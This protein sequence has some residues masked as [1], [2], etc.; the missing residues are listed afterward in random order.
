[1]D[2][3]VRVTA[4][5]EREG[6]S[7]DSLFTALAGGKQ[8]VTWPDFRALFAQLE[9]GLLEEHLAQLWKTFDKNGD[10]GVSREEFLTAFRNV[11]ASAAIPI[12]AKGPVQPSTAKALALAEEVCSRVAALLRR[13]GRTEDQL[14]DA[15]AAGKGIVVWA[16]FRALFH[17]LEAALTEP[18]LEELWRVFDKDGDGGVSRDEFKKSLGAVSST[19]QALVKEISIKVLAA[20]SRGGRSVDQLFDALSS[21]RSQVT[22]SDFSALFAQ[23]EPTLSTQQLEILWRT[24]D[25]DG[26]GGVSREEFQKSL[27][28]WP[29]QVPAAPS[30]AASDACV[31]VAA[32]LR[33]EGKTVEMLFDALSAGKA[34]VLWQDF[35][36]LFAQLEP[37][38]SAQELEGLWRG[39]DKDGDGGVT[40]DEFT[41]ALAPATELAANPPSLPP[42]AGPPEVGNSLA[43]ALW[44]AIAEVATLRAGPGLPRGSDALQTAVVQQLSAFDASRQGSLDRASFGQALRSYS[45]GLPDAAIEALWQ[46]VAVDGKATVLDLA[47]RLL[48]TH[49][50]AQPKPAEGSTAPAP[51]PGGPFWSALRRLRPALHERGLR[52]RQAFERMLP[53]G[54]A[55]LSQQ[56]LAAGAASLVGSPLPEAHLLALFGSMTKNV[57]LGATLEE[58]VAAFA[59]SSGEG[60]DAF[61]KELFGRAGRSLLLRAR[62]SLSSAFATLDI[63]GEGEI[64]KDGFRAALVQFGDLN[65][66][67]E[68]VDRLWELARTIGGYKGDAIDFASFKIL[69]ASAPA[70]VKSDV[71]PQAA[72]SVLLDP[73]PSLEESCTHLDRLQRLEA[74]RD[75]V[76]R[77]GQDGVVP[78]AAL[79]SAIREAAPELS[80][81]EVAQ[82]CR[83]AP[84]RGGPLGREDAYSYSQLFERFEDGHKDWHPL[85]AR[86]RQAAADICRYLDQRVQAWGFA[87][88]ALALGEPVQ[89]MPAPVLLSHLQRFLPPREEDRRVAELSLLRLGRP[90]SGGAIDV[91]ELCQR[92]DV[93]ARGGAAA[94]MASSA[95]AIAAAGGTAGQDNAKAC[96]REK[97][98]PVDIHSLG[99][100]RLAE[101]AAR[102]VREF[103]D[104]TAPFDKLSRILEAELKPPP[105]ARQQDQLKKWLEPAT[106][107]Y[108][109][110]PML[111]G[112]EVTVER[113]SL[114]A[115]KELR[116]LYPQWA[117][118][119]PEARLM[120]LSQPNTMEIQPRRHV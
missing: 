81:G 94:P 55:R 25:A 85:H 30:T 16:D 34:V 117:R 8:E 76:S 89:V 84:Q 98:S 111:I 3:C 104:G 48:R 65:L 27:R 73:G 66:T 38:L 12:P 21:G 64:Q 77:R 45:P 6:K 102:L 61:G 58:F 87:S 109:H 36:A 14:F 24:F 7:I 26:D 86:E 19:A 63:T 37:T 114:T 54:M 107:G 108:V 1:Q 72:G 100:S 41:R 112:F 28:E 22:F 62:G 57:E 32:A 15:L 60:F 106:G 67:S 59:G 71:R 46:Q 17:E 18:Q 110:W 13:E 120:C 69:F 42:L 83:L 97:P 88:L 79:T 33:R 70:E 11:K 50:P 2:V 29:T 105:T 53:A 68:Q 10:G 91:A 101:V 39:F 51:E 56:S 43:S 93:L 95:A 4:A 99:L 47:R 96:L 113:I 20:L 103:P 9:P 35:R 23:L 74:L 52:L 40:R 115:S 78:L 31:R 44:E 119:E 92:F 80:D 118:G 90:L 82:I 49:Q 5:L 116:K 75:A